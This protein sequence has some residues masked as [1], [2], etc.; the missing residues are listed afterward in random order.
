MQHWAS[1]QP[2]VAGTELSATAPDFKS[3]GRAIDGKWPQKARSDLAQV[4]RL[5]RRY[6]LRTDI[7]RFYGGIYTHSIPWALHTKATAKANRSAALLG[8]RIDYWLRLGQDQQ[9]VGIPIG[10]DTSLVLAELLMQR[11]DQE[12]LTKTSDMKGF[13]FIDDYELSFRTRTQAEDAFHLLQACLA[14]YELTLNEKKTTVL[15]L[16][17]PLE[18]SWATGIKLLNLRTS[19]RGQEADLSNYF[20]RIYEVH[21]ENPDESVFQFAI[22]RLRSE[23]IHPANWPLFQRLLLLCVA[24]E[25]ACFPYVLEQLILRRNAGAGA[26]LPQLEEIVNTLIEEHST[27]KHSSEVANAAWACLAL[28]LSMSSKAVNSISQ[29]DDPVVAL[30]ALDCEQEGLVSGQLDKALWSAHMTGDALYDE[31]W[32]LAYEANI[33]GWLPTVGG[34]DHVAA[35]ANFGFLKASG[36]SFYDRTR[37]KPAPAAPVPL[38]NLPTPQPGAAIGY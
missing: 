32:L 11:C 15:E 8:N 30:L 7:T 10:P 14:E 13:R 24:P 2:L 31:N 20:S 33:K 3:V 6:V 23:R 36:V 5:G 34:G 26:L 17:Q 1:I 12:L 18:P 21:L 38:P 27:L 35:D 29:C 9:T 28:G 22:A 37:A 19:Q 4:A 16:P 25:P